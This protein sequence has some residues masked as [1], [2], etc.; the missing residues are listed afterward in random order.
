[1]AKFELGQKVIFRNPLYSRFSGS[2]AIVENV[3]DE[4]QQVSE[5]GIRFDEVKPLD[6]TNKCF[7]AYEHELVK[8]TG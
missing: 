5:Y 1:M 8:I 7:L 3:Y 4:D 2:T 6:L